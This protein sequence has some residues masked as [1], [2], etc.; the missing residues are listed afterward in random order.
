ML[1]QTGSSGQE[2]FWNAAWA[3]KMYI[4]RGLPRDV[5]HATS[6][7]DA[8]YFRVPRMLCPAGPLVHDFCP[9]G[10]FHVFF[11]PQGI[12]DDS[13]APQGPFYDF[14][15]CGA[16]SQFLCPAGQDFLLQIFC[17]R[18]RGTS[19]TEDPYNSKNGCYRNSVTGWG[20]RLL[21]SGCT[22]DL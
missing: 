11:A 3:W 22:T 17:Y 10:P 15:P 12:F 8:P 2:L 19:V 18:G 14:C 5:T 4:T 6:R 20:V 13:N 21:Q 16:F 1:C 7:V 9:A